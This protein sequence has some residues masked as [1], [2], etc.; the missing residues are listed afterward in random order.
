MARAD[1][2][3]DAS[4]AVLFA[5][6]LLALFLTAVADGVGAARWVLLAGGAVLTVLTGWDVVV[7][8]HVTAAARRMTLGRDP[9][10]LGVDYGLGE[11]CW[12]RVVPARVPYRAG[13]R[14]ELLARGSPIAAKEALRC[15][16]LR[17][18]V[19]FVA[20]AAIGGLFVVVLFFCW[21]T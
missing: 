8:A 10:R 5:S 12:M 16:L 4:F 3:D 19:A 11:D 9:R 17:R 15:S 18:F 13:D 20:M 1:G 6:P 21:S 7:W 2:R 14:H